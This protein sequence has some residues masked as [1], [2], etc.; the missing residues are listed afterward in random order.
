MKKNL[1][2]LLL[3]YL[4][5]NGDITS[6][7]TNNM[8][9]SISKAPTE[10]NFNKYRIGGYGEILFQSMN[11]G[12]DRYKDPAGAPKQTRSYIS[13]PRAVFAFDYKFRSDIILS[14]ELEIEYGGAGSAMEL[15]YEEGGEY[16][17]E[18]EK[19]GEIE[20][21]QFHITKRFSDAFNIRAGHMIVPVGITNSHH[22]PIY[23]F[24]TARPEGEMT[25]L[26]CT[27][28]ET[29]IAILGYVSSF[30]Y[31][32]MMVNGLDPNGFSSI[33]W[34]QGGKQGM[35]ETSVMTSPA[36]AG[37][38]EYAG[39]KHLRLGA[40]GYFN[41]TAKNASK[42]EKMTGIKAPVTI[43]TFDAQ[44]L[45][46][47][48]AIRANAVYGNLGASRALSEINKGISKATTFPRTPVAKN[49]VTY[50]IEAGYNIMKFFNTKEKLMPFARYE[51]YNS[52]EKVESGMAEMPINKRDVYTFGLNYYMM[53]N[54]VLKA[55]YSIRKLNRGKF[56]DE[57][58]FGLAL[59]YTG[60]FS[61]K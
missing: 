60:W 31:E 18:V 59:V 44:Y 37:R 15:E 47:D 26:P 40:S 55:D 6:Q 27:W 28:H 35:F 3:I 56:N 45:T 4:L 8:T 33:N 32:V 49:A 22:E 36:F 51:Y 2:L 48:M 5:A 53:P 43:A 14:T 19:G 9:D 34:I 38:I 7:N 50:S 16:E 17:M 61:K 57:N 58:T 20:L 30:R 42:P 12:A 29:G 52:A 21:E 39:I 41:N 10:W 46:K 54:M 1:F 11:Y 25:I 23:F 13:I 24:T